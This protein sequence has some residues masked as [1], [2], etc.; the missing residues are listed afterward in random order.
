[1]S[2][3]GSAGPLGR[4]FASESPPYRSSEGAGSTQNHFIGTTQQ[5]AYQWDVIG[6]YG[7][8]PAVEPISKPPQNTNIAANN[9]H[10][11]AQQ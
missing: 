4:R 10:A 5:C 3:L 11:S 9:G 8:Y 2:H 6:F 1:M 7:L